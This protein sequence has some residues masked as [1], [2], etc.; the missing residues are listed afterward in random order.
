MEFWG[1]REDLRGIILI[2]TIAINIASVAEM[3]TA[4]DDFP[5]RAIRVDFDRGRE[6]KL[7]LRDRRNETT[8]WYDR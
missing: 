1:R 4:V 6:T 7:P 8:V 5:S 3:A 2:K